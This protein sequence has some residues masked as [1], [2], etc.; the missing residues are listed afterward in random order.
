MARPPHTPSPAARYFFVFLIGLFAGMVAV[1]VTLRA[2]DARKT[3]EHRFPTATMQVM[4]AHVAQL[5]AKVEADRCAPADVLPHVR[6]LRALADDLEPTF[7]W[8]RDDPRFAEHAGA[9][10]AALDG[11]SPSTSLACPGARAAVEK[12]NDGCTACHRDF[13]G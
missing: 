4:A 3:W 7:P 9:M 12:I 6:T 5:Q 10:R 2:L 8:L 13:L 11:V 1:V